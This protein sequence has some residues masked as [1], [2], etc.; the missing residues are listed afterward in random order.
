[1]NVLK[2]LTTALKSVLTPMALSLVSVEVGIDWLA[3]GETVQ[4]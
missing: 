2:G 3:M 1:M 4:V